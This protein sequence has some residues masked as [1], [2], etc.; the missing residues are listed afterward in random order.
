VRVLALQNHSAIFLQHKQ[1]LVSFI[2]KMLSNPSR[3]LGMDLW[4]ACVGFEWLSRISNVV[5]MQN[6]LSYCFRK[7][8]SFICTKGPFFRCKL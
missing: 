3:V 7:Y 5:M 1:G 8:D 6:W 4:T 2:E